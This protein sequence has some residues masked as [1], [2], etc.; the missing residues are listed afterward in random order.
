VH[1]EAFDE[2][3]SDR[4]GVAGE[5]YSHEPTPE[6]AA[7]FQETIDVLMNQLE[8][9]HRPI[10]ALT[11]QGYTPLEIST[12]LRCTERMVYRVL[13]RV[14]TLLEQMRDRHEDEAEEDVEDE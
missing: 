2:T 7:L 9:R 5:P 14:Q 10:L 6:E 4:S 1:R 8:E 12:K 13:D 11:L 3:P